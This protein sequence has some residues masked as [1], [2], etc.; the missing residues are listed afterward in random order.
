MDEEFCIDKEFIIPA[1]RN[2]R[3]EGC[4]YDEYYPDTFITRSNGKY[5]TVDINGKEILPIIYNSIN[6]IQPNYFIDIYT[7]LPV[8]ATIQL[9][10]YYSLANLSIGRILLPFEYDEATL[11][12]N[13]RWKNE[14]IFRLRKGRKHQLFCIEKEILTEG[15]ED[16]MYCNTNN[17][18]KKDDKYGIIND[19]GEVICPIENIL[20]SPIGKDCIG[21]TGKINYIISK[22][23]ISYALGNIKKNEVYIDYICDEITV[24]CSGLRDVFLLK[25]EGK[26]G[27][28]NSEG[29][30]LIAIDYDKIVVES[31]DTSSFPCDRFKLKLYKAGNWS[32]YIIE[33]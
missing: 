33:I 32:S 20:I 15:Y 16:I 30:L 28:L 7:H 29:K 11:Y 4:A 24:L 25:K 2:V 19:L 26:Y 22:D 1:N 12:R 27:C 9:G 10:K 6:P 31:H 14:T 17:I 18:V 3:A 8:Y 23:G 13:K 21:E 5:G